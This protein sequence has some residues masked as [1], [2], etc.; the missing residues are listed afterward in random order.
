MHWFGS[1]I[2]GGKAVILK[3]ISPEWIFEAVSEEKGT[4]V[5]LLVPSAQDILLKLDSGEI[6]LKDYRLSQ[7]RL[8]HIG[9]RAQSLLRWSNTG[10]NTFP[11][12]AMIPPMV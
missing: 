1:F 4:I 5:W 12:W 7:W 8:M 3:G 10:K 2:V 11:I 9:S 6:K